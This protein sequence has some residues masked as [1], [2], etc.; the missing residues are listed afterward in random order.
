M[1]VLDTNVLSE[2]MRPSEQRSARVFSW[3]R[4]QPATALFTTAV[5]TAEMMSGVA[6]MPEGR[7]KREVGESVARIIAA[8]EERI[9]SFDHAAAG[10]YAEVVASRRLAGRLVGS[11]DLMILAVARANR[12]AVATRNVSDFDDC[13]VD[14]IDPWEG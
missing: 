13:G 8:F 7:R 2:V 14:L 11:L 6:I 4:A 12:M 3:M 5:T 10:H 1:I 9:L